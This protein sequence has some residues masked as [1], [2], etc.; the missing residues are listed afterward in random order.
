MSYGLLSFGAYIPPL[1]LSREAI[2]RAVGW[3]VPGLDEPL[4]F[5]FAICATIVM[6]ATTIQ[7]RTSTA[8]LPANANRAASLRMPLRGR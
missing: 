6:I 2:F 5:A 3:A 8:A 1:R 7:N 4:R